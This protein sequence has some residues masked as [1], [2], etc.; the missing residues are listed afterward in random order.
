MTGAVDIP[1]GTTPE[2][3]VEAAPELTAMPIVAQRALVVL[4]DGNATLASMAELLGTDQALASAVLRQVNSAEAMPNR[5][6]GNLREAV[7]RIGLE[8]LWTLL[9][10]SSAGAMLDRGLPPYALARRTAW[11]HAAASSRAAR[12]IAVRAGMQQV[13]VEEASIAGL[14]HDVGKSVL[15]SVAP[16]VI[17]RA[18]SMAR[19]RA[20]PIWQA[21]QEVMGFDHG[22]VGAALLRRW[23]LPEMVVDAVQHHHHYWE[24]SGPFAALVNVAD[25][26]AHA[27]GAVGSAGACLHPE[28]DLDAVRQ[29]NASPAQI[30]LVLAD[31]RAVDE[32]GV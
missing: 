29:L 30:D 31:L 15:S 13:Q 1:A 5:R 21:E 18:V 7:A 16:E 25:A 17:A 20:L 8:A 10:K 19:A 4:Q 32:V 28:I 11:R 2:R 26:A 14:L 9:I 3:L 24:V 6:I 23:G 22:H 12:F 27:V